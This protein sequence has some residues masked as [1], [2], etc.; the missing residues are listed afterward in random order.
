MT[1]I[2]TRIIE[3]QIKIL[4]DTKITD[5]G[6]TS[7]GL[8]NHILKAVIVNSGLCICYAGKIGKAEVA[9][10]NVLQAQYEL[11]PTLDYLLEKHKSWDYETDFIV[12]ALTMA[13]PSLHRIS[14]G[15]LTSTIATWLGNQD[16]F[17]YYQKKYDLFSNMVEFPGNM[18]LY[19][20]LAFR[21]VT[22]AGYDDVGEFVIEVK[23]DSD[24]F[25]YFQYA[26]GV[27]AIRMSAKGVASSIA[28]QT[29]QEGG[30]TYSVLTPRKAGIGAI[31]IHFYQGNLG[32]LIYP[33]TEDKPVF[34]SNVSMDEFRD[35][36]LEKYGFEIS[37]MNVSDKSSAE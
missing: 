3:N 19:M 4:S 28:Y 25:K 1:L 34:F 31:G 16:A 8:N 30:Y 7:Q 17:N 33:I 27:N 15:Q 6:G 2:V 23:N 11:K 32:V 14:G 18:S 35:K 21:N 10:K 24:G 26:A 36:I 20:D 12:A 5:S 9:I 13:S 22:Q 37:G 29:A